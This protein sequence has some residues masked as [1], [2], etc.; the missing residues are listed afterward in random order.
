M[1]KWQV[2]KCEVTRTR[3]LA[4]TKEN[5]LKKIKKKKMG[6]SF[7]FEEGNSAF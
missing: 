3:E 7:H 2:L 1:L 4:I 5:V 6:V